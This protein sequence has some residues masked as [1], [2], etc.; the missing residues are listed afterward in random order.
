MPRRYDYD[1]WYPQP[2]KPRAAD[3]IKAR[4]KRGKIGESWW[5]D[6]WIAAL[7]PLLDSG[8]LSRGRSYARKGQVLDLD[9]GPG[10][11]TSRVQG[12]RAR[13]YKVKIAVKTLTDAEWSEV[14]EALAGQA[15]FAAKLLAGEMPPDVETAFWAAHVSLFPTRSDDLH[16]DCSC[17]D[18]A[19]PCKHVAAVYFLLG[20][21]FD[22]DPFLIFHL[23]GKDKDQ[24]LAELHR[25]RGV[26]DLALAEDSPAYEVAPAP[27]SLP[28]S[29]EP[30]E[31][32]LDRFWD[33]GDGLDGFSAP[34][35]RPA[36]EA[37]L[38]K[39]LG[40]PPF[41][42]KPGEITDPLAAAYQSVSDHALLL[43]LGE[44]SS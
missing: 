31:A 35:V 33:M 7:E 8:R 17:P 19:N 37:G 25:R 22:Q 12:S 39:R 13:P 40:K 24:L 29:I 23:R 2:S 3:G 30:L 18:Y 6:K 10:V 14:I 1:D 4:S 9:I 41:E 26:A 11:V 34:V 32:V 15:I 44:E 28:E 43:A 5:A 42:R 21:R 20:E 27:E 36:V 16:T 38:L